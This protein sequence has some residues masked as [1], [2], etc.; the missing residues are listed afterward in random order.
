M[1]QKI[2]GVNFMTARGKQVMDQWIKE[3]KQ[4]T[5]HFQDGK[6]LT[7]KL[8]DYDDIEIVLE[9]QQEYTYAGKPSETI[10][11]R[12]WI[13]VQKAPDDSCHD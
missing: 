10:I 11:C 9:S 2:I 13:Y 7:G 5:V 3:E 1:Y 8:I 6:K 4:I 12:N